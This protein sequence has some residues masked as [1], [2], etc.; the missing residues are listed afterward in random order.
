MFS[1]PVN[2][3]SK[4]DVSSSMDEILPWTSTS[5]DVAVVTPVMILSSVDLPDPF[6]PRIATT[7]PRGKS[8]VTSLSAVK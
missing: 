5:P 4:P 2:S 6:L 1:M 8:T 7:S 3:M